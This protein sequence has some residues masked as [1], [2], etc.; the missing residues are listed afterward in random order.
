ME[1]L[2]LRVL[3]CELLGRWE[4][5]KD[6]VLAGIKTPLWDNEEYHWYVDQLDHCYSLPEDECIDMLHYLGYDRKLILK[7]YG[8]GV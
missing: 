7:T 6:E 4:D 5:N 8:T 1:E 3:G 2:D